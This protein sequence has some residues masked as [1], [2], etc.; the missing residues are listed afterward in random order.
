MC[1][2]S[3][4]KADNINNKQLI[5]ILI[6]FIGTIIYIC[7][8]ISKLNSKTSN[9]ILVLTIILTGIW[10]IKERQFY[11]LKN[12]LYKDKRFFTGNTALIFGITCLI[13]GIIVL[14]MVYID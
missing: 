5:A 2:K 11:F 12:K 6:P 7:S 8:I 3:K 4:H 10:A 9:T 1:N 14:I 13:T